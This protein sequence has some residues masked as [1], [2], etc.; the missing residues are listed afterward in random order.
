[1]YSKKQLII[2]I[3][4]GVVLFLLGG[5]VGIIAIQGGAQQG[6]IKMANS[7]SSKVVSSIVAYGQVKSIDA[8]NLTLANLG[9]SL[10]VPVASTAQIYAFITPATTGKSKTTS[11]PIQQTV[12][13]QNIKVG[14]NVNVTIRLLATGQ[15]EGSSVII[16]PASK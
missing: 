7:L 1:M 10:T 12:S 6:K 16:L 14:D 2:L 13:F 15:L 9:D 3:I 4:V 8:R 11:A 5:A